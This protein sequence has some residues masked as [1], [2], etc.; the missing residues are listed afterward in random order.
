M[1][2]F[3]EQSLASR[4]SETLN[5]LNNADSNPDTKKKCFWLFFVKEFKEELPWLEVSTPLR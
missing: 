3:V 2:V 4:G 5:L 1:T